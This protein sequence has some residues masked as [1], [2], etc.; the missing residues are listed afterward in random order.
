[1]FLVG[2][3][4]NNLILGDGLLGTELHRQ[5]GWDYI[6]R[7]KDGLD[8]CNLE[9]FEYL[10]KDYDTIV[11]CIANTD[12][13]SSDKDSHFN[14]NYVGVINL[15]NYC[16]RYEKKLV[17]ISTDYIYSGS[18][19]EAQEIDIPVHARNWYSYTKLLA[20]GYVQAMCNNYLLI[21]TL[22]K[23]R[24]FPYEKAITTQK[25]NFDYIDNIA[26]LIIK[27]IDK[28]AFGIFNVGRNTPWTIYEMA[29]E[30]NIDVY[31]WNQILDPTMPTNITTDCSKM[32]KFLNENIGGDSLL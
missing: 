12:T 24:P 4:M 30:T 3:K 29:L 6:S 2:L 19:S 17:H 27:L 23:P 14:V 25:G 22:F 32:R 5:T 11:N 8:F 16:N 28:K 20:D 1:M 26:S 15:T 31:P 10:M 21:R 9:T 18:L 13:Y 7:K